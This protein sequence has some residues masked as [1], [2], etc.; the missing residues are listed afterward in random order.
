MGAVS[1]GFGVEPLRWSEIDAYARL[2][3]DI[4]QPWEARTVRAMSEAYCRW[5]KLGED[6][7]CMTPDEVNG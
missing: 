1:L 7:L 5:R 6:A 3:G 4:T 2:T